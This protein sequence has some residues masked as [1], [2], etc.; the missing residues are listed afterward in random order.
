MIPGPPKLRFLHCNHHFYRT[1]ARR[2]YHISA[3]LGSHAAFKIIR[4][5]V[6]SQASGYGCGCHIIQRYI[7][8]HHSRSGILILTVSQ[9]VL[10]LNQA[11]GYF[12]ILNKFFRPYDKFHFIPYSG[13][14]PVLPEGR[15]RA[16]TVHGIDH[17]TLY[18]G[19]R[20]SLM[21]LIR[22]GQRCVFIQSAV[23]IFCFVPWRTVPY[24]KPVAS[25]LFQE[26][27][28]IKFKRVKYPL[29]AAQ[30]D[31][32]QPDI[33][34]IVHGAK[35][36]PDM[37]FFRKFRRF[38]FTLKPYGPKVISY[39]R[40]IPVIRNSNLFPAIL[41]ISLS[42]IKVLCGNSARLFCFIAVLPCSA[43]I[44]GFSALM[45]HYHRFLPFP[46]FAC[47]FRCMLSTHNN[48]L[49]GFCRLYL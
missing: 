26:I 36:Q 48:W 14:I 38:K 25:F 34:C 20:F 15:H 12:T 30:I 49:R 22:L 5:D 11:C 6:P 40:Q 42:G 18:L 46:C 28:N 10:F 13:G 19:N 3:A 32:V 33:R 39:F 4:Y 47:S 27:C 1:A 7:Q 45:N 41:R 29:M 8:A 23:Y 2:N 31:I 24:K 35:P 44:Y 43:Q 37:L 9:P 16:G 17:M 21:P